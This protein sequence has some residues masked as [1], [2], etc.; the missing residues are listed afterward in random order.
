MKDSVLRLAGSIEA[1]FSP[2]VMMKLWDSNSKWCAMQ[3]N[4]LRDA[5][6]HNRQGQTF[7][8]KNNTAPHQ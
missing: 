3:C 5:K 7:F 2:T 1:L 6:Q 4:E 8:E